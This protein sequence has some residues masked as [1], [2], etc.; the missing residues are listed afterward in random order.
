MKISSGYLLKTVA[1]KSIVIPVGDNPDFGGMITLN[2]T[3]TFL[4]NL[5]QKNTTKENMLEDLL[6]EYD[7]T[8]DEAKDD[9]DA[10]IEKLS[11]LHIL[12][13]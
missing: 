7:V 9:I 13:D 1:G 3:G 8:V 6:K 11:S 2:D 4:W 5:L 10:F 12:E